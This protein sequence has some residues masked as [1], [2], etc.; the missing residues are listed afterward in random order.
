[1]SATPSAREARRVALDGADRRRIYLFRHGAVDYMDSNGNVV[2]DTD[3]VDLSDRG[4][5]QAA[6]MRALFDGVHIDKAICSGLPRTRQTAETVVGDRDLSVGT[7]PD[8]EEIRQSQGEFTGD[9]DIVEDIAFS[10][11]RATD[12]NAQFLAGERYSDFYA[13]NRGRSDQKRSAFVRYGNACALDDQ[14]AVQCRIFVA[15]AKRI[16]TPAIRQACL[17]GRV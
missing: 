12:V 6:A 14:A 8:F 7:Y 2:P 15:M 3:N 10:H 13:R 17:S 5:K 4:K 1:M 11:W 16:T 9:Y